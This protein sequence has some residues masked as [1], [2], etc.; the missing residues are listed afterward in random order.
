MISTLK[1]VT[2][3]LLNAIIVHFVCNRHWFRTSW[4]ERRH[5]SSCMFKKQVQ[6]V[7]ME[8]RY[9]QG[10]KMK[11]VLYF[12]ALHIL[13]DTVPSNLREKK[14][15]YQLSRVHFRWL[16][17]HLQKCL[18]QSFSGNSVETIPIKKIKEKKRSSSQKQKKF[19]PIC[20]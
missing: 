6:S 1:T 4:R 20:E 8:R 19:H 7:L 10:W 11:K 14:K 15:V 9:L 16:I 18:E 2:L 12:K 3:A 13:M 17:K 5:H